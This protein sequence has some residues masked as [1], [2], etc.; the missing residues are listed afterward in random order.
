MKQYK[1]IV[2]GAGPAGLCAA[3]SAA[4]ALGEKGQVLLLESGDQTGRKLL[5]S[6]SGQCNF[7][8]DLE[9][10]EFLKKLGAYA[11]YLKPAFYNFDN[12][13]LVR[14][15]A[16]SGCEHIVREDGKVFPA[17]FKAED[18][19]NALLQKLFL[20]GGKL[21]LNSRLVFLKKLGTGFEL[22]LENG[23]SLLAEK[24]ILCSG[25][26][27]Y[28]LTGSDGKAAK[29][30]RVF[31]HRPVPFRPHLC[32]VG[33]KDF[34]NY[35]NCAGISLSYVQA[36]FIAQSGEFDAM[37]DL[38]ITHKGFSGP[39]IL[40]NSHRL[41]KGDEIVIKWFPD[42][43]PLLPEMIKYNPKMSVINGLWL[44]HIPPALLRAILGHLVYEYSKMNCISKLDRRRIIEALSGSSYVIDSLG[45]LS[46]SMASAGGIPLSEINAKTMESRLCPGLFMAGEMM[47]YALPSG[48]FNIQIAC[49]TGWLAGQNAVKEIKK[50][51]NL[52]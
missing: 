26:A 46:T 30:T 29:L 2:V 35:K 28:P 52:A 14:L 32:S 21:E 11:M 20:A 17:S 5:L 7:T 31:G 51:L 12:L 47:D 9:K 10:D 38:L 19:R 45:S 1:V 48:G 13:A 39:L 27:S 15:L 33:L 49:S 16:E 43:E 41:A 25:G 34:D 4:L 8:N 44:T 3:I 37:G 40:D 23:K 6:G 50:N 42:I 18:V 24:L 22:G 36:K